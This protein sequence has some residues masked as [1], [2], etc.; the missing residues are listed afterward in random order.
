MKR[1]FVSLI[2]I[3]MG[4]GNALAVGAQPDVAL[5][6]YNQDLALVKEV[7]SLEFK[8]GIFDYRFS[9]VPSRID[10]TSVHF[11]PRQSID[12]ISI[13]EQNYQYDLV[14][15]DKIFD[16]YLDHQITA[17]GKNG[18]LYEGTLLSRSGESVVV[19]GKD[20]SLSVVRTEELTDYKFDKLPDG[21][22]TR[23]TLVWKF[24]S[25]VKGPIDCEVSYLTNGMNWHSEYVAVVAEDDKSLELSG[26]VSIENNSGG[27]FKN[28][29][30]KLIA[31]DIHRVPAKGIEGAY[32]MNAF[33]SEA[34][35]APQF[36]EKAFFEYHLYTLQRRADILSNEIKQITLFPAS[37]VKARKVYTYDRGYGRRGDGTKVKVSLEFKNGQA[38]GLGTPLPKGTIRVYKVDSDK[39]LE[40]VGEDE[41]DHTPKDE[42]VR[43]YVGDA[44]DIIGEPKAAD[45]KEISSSVS[46]ESYE[47]KLRNH[48]KEKV[49][50]VVVEKLWKST[51]WE[52]IKSNFD[53]HKKDANTIEFTIPVSPDGETILTYTVRYKRF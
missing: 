13:L 5:T 44:F 52:I 26:W 35:V 38:E 28:A 31:G 7:R 53:F 23:P 41:I 10:P 47:V 34:K 6:V 4:V 3:M 48:K 20:G 51:D 22:L 11:K 24:D 46:E 15:P 43:V 27:S 50:V 33:R 29:R 19:Q 25:A 49:E 21:L 40:Y 1:K 39:S 42:M 30:V 37:E 14:S 32:G 45:F 36:E 2:I 8:P 17:I 18:Q 16:K 9:E 12:K